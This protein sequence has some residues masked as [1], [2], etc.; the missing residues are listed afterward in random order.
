M[1]GPTL[2]HDRTELTLG[3]QTVRTAI[4]RLHRA[5]PDCPGRAPNARLA[6]ELVSSAMDLFC[7][8][9]RGGAGAPLLARRH[10]KAAVE[11]V[12]RLES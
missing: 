1:T 4:V 3:K 9:A 7:S 2:F 10:A 5:I 6:L 8:V 11:L 12:A